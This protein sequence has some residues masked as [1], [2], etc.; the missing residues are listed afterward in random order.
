ME[1]FLVT[2]FLGAG[3]TT[4]I[5]H[6]LTSEIQ[7]PKKMAV[8]VNEVGR[9]GIDGTLLSGQNVDI[10]ELTSGCIC[11]T[12]KTDFVRA[13]VEIHDRVDPDL[14]VV[15]ATGVAQP[16][17]ILELLFES[18]MREFCRIRSLVTVVDAEF[19]E[20]RDLLGPFYNNQIRSADTLLLNKVDL[21]NAEALQKVEDSIRELNP[22]ARTIHTQFC[23][24]H[25]S[26]LLG[27]DVKNPGRHLHGLREHGHVQDMGF[28]TFSFEDTHPVDREKL[29]QFLETLPPN[30][31]RLKGWVRF[32]DDT[33]FL[34]LAAGRYRLR[35]ADSQR[36]TTLSFV[37]RNCD[38]AQILSNLR[39]C[40]IN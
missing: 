27:G 3:K 29:V 22:E 8:L 12:M 17:D 7:G 36:A 23:R 19:F 9:I 11:C 39:D 28:Q 18:D 14:L 21:V 40:L 38:E 34:D 26:M 32:P 37:G 20:A 25:P 2:G 5:R 1:I 24:V 13:L 15:E 33:A 30:L 31:F 16:G 10:V 6:L 4:L 35:P